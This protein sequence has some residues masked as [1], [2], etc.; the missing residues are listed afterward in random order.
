MD[1]DIINYKTFDTMIDYLQWLDN[2]DNLPFPAGH[3]VVI[4]IKELNFRFVKVGNGEDAL[5][6]LPNL[7]N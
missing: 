3:V 6:D 5:I 2:M 1:K 4:S 7:L